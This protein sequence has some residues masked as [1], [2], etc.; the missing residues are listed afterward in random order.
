MV[1]QRSVKA[2]AIGSSP[3]LSANFGGNV[4]KQQ[5]GEIARLIH[6][7]KGSLEDFDFRTVRSMLEQADDLMFDYLH[8]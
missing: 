4:T 8:E 1:E 5:A 7:A 2:P 3:I 6:Q